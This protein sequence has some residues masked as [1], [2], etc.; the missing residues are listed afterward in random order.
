MPKRPRGRQAK[1]LEKREKAKRQVE[2]GLVESK[3]N[4]L[5]DEEA[6]VYQSDSEQ[7][8]DYELRPR[9]FRVPDDNE[10][11]E[12]L[13]VKTA[14]GKIQRVMTK[15]AKAEAKAEDEDEDESDSDQG[16]SDAREDEDGSDEYESED[17][18]TKAMSEEERLVA[19]KERVAEIAYQL[20]EDPDE[21]LKLLREVKETIQRTKLFK[22]KQMYILAL[23]PIFKNLIPGYRIRPLTETEQKEKVSKEVRKIRDFEQGLLFHYKEYVDLLRDFTRKGRNTEP[24]SI[25]FILATSAVSAVCEMLSTVPYFNFQ[26]ELIEAVVERLTSKR[27]DDAFDKCIVTI[28][29]IFQQD[30]EGQISFQVVR[31]LSKMIKARRYKVQP[32]VVNSLLH[33]RLLSELAAKA[34]LEKVDKPEEPKVKKKDRQK[35]SK[36]ERKARK[37]RKA[38][39]A[40]MMHAETA[41]SAEE[42]ERLQGETL[43][44]VFALYFNILR[45]RSKDLMSPALEGLAKFAHLINADLFG[46][47]LEVLREL[48]QERQQRYVDG[49]YEFKESTTREALLCVVTA[50][51][52]LSGQAG[53]S[54][55][56][57]LSFFINH[58]YSSLY[59]LALNADIE[60]SHRTLR[61]DDPLEPTE[62]SHK[63]K[64]DIS[65]EMEMVVR[66]FEAIFF[67]Q[68]SMIGRLRILAFAKRLA[69][70]MLQMPQKSTFASLK[71]LDKMISKFHSRLSAAFTTD[72]RIANGVYHMEVDDPEQSNPE[73]A[74][75]W[76]VFLLEKHFDP[77]VQKGA[78]SILKA[79]ST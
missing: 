18:D 1:D 27:R 44:L 33:L 36:K 72:D 21:N 59:A 47:L 37:E 13:P 38:I 57:D 65:T 22:I 2:E 73:A 15:K 11:Q 29:K 52:L 56:L 78:K 69:T 50:F 49:H 20:A 63:H 25:R 32:S 9:K 6:E 19:A 75:M 35:L 43:K 31:L 39:E 55:N 30:E 5:G 64:V 60:Y 76:E 14:D 67:K 26:T 61:L 68:R 58:F 34:D 70:C 46:D 42:R 62:H 23:V 54:M 7:E 16:E 77:T 71:I 24:G 3:W 17:E 48:I 66:A 28:E 8:Q 53:E 4:A 79:A 10:L 51:A 41:V 45:E 12:R 40:E 74:T